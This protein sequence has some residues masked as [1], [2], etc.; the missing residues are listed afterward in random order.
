M[1]I[2]ASGQ[3]VPPLGGIRPL[4]EI[5]SLYSVSLPC[6]MRG[7][8]AA[9][10]PALG[11]PLRPVP[12]HAEQTCLK[13]SSPVVGSAAAASEVRRLLGRGVVGFLSKPFDVRALLSLVDAVR[14][15]RVE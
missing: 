5:A 4:P 1:R 3:V 10:S 7:A 12:W 11:A 15:S 2:V 9:L 6:A 13:A 8:Q 14:A